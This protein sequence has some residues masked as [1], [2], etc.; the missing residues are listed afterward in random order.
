MP[1][2]NR[3]TSLT[4]R[5]EDEGDTFYVC[6]TNRGEPFREGINIGIQNNNFDK[7]VDIMLNDEEAI[8]LRDVLVKLYPL[9]EER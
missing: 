3:N 6:Y 8:E 1:K 2:I 5:C 7:S 4:L 9:T